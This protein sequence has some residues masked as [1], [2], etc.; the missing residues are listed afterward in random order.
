MRNVEL[1]AL[2]L[3][4]NS[5]LLRLVQLAD[6]ITSCT[7]ALVVGENRFAPITFQYIRPLLRSEGGRIGGVGLKIHPAH[8]C[9]NLYHWLVGDRDY[10]HDSSRVRIEGGNLLPQRVLAN[11][12]PTRGGER[13]FHCG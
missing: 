3:T 8:R 6:L 5:K 12:D 13:V 2:L 7:T 1:I 11:F 9:P 10:M 4:T